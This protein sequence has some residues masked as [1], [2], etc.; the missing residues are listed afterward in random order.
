[1]YAWIKYQLKEWRKRQKE[2]NNE[3][4][5]CLVFL[6]SAILTIGFFGRTKGESSDAIAQRS[7]VP[8]FD[9]YDVSAAIFGHDHMYQRSQIN[10]TSYM[11]IGV[12]GKTPINYF[13][14]LRNVVNYK[15]NKD[16]EGEKA[17]G[18]AVT[19]VPPNTANMKDAE[20]RAFQNLLARIKE[21]ILN[22]DLKTYYY[23]KRKEKRKYKELMANKEKRE[24][25]IKEEII[26]KL[27]SHIWWRYYNL[28]GQLIDHAFL[29]RYKGNYDNVEPIICPGEHIR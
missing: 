2:D 12:S 22:S 11:C 14:F 1:E 13:D 16:E 26:D 5:F 19:F 20:S 23:F 27:V 6:H 21:T 7:L 4:E 24:Q 3:P 8:L 29:P 9:A 10:N 28:K 25:F 15:I 17:R 18:Y